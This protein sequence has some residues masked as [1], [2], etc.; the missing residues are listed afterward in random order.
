M[1]IQLYVYIYSIIYTRIYYIHLH[2]LFTDIDPDISYE[3]WQ[4]FT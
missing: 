2:Y 3:L 1:C 4:L